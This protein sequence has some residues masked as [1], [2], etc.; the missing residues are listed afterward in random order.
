MKKRSQL[1]FMISAIISTQ[2][3]AGLEIYSSSVL[4]ENKN[5]N[6]SFNQSGVSG[7]ASNKVHGYGKDMPLGLALQIIVPKSWHVNLNSGTEEMLVNWEGKTSWQYVL[8]NLAKQNNLNINIDWTS[9]VVDVYSLN[10]A[11]SRNIE[12]YE[13][14]MEE[15]R[16]GVLNKHSNSKYKNHMEKEISEKTENGS[17][18]SIEEIYNQSNVKPIDGKIRTF[19]SNVYNNSINEDTQAKFIL[20]PGTMLSENI[21]MWGEYTGWDIKWR[22]GIDYK[23]TNE[24]SFNGNLKRVIENALKLYSEGE[25]PL[26]AEFYDGNK[27]VEIKEFIFKDPKIKIEQ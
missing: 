13:E 6:Y 27:V 18:L 7:E 16:V 17:N 14:D 4:A 3:Y 12:R 2:S 23:V 24:V 19:V 20:K 22:S 10:A 11:K 25:K 15:A 21:T 1:A 8:E 9:K 5:A 26:K